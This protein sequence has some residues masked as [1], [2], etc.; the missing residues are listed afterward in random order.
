MVHQLPLELIM[1]MRSLGLSSANI[2]RL[3]ATNKRLRST[4]RKFT[5]EQHRLHTVKRKRSNN[6]FRRP[7]KRQRV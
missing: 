7:S 4:L 2:V 3:A 1:Y 5:E 6:N